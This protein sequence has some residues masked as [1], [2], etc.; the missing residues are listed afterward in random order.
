MSSI[1]S[2]L[3]PPPARD[4]KVNVAIVKLSSPHTAK[5]TTSFMTFRGAAYQFP[6][7]MFWHLATFLFWLKRLKK[8]GTNPCAMLK[9]YPEH[10]TP[11]DW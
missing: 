7:Y 5:S 1:V 10:S 2:C 3:P 6:G 8:L 11:Y 4:R 9:L